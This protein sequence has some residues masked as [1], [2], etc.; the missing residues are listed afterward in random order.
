MAKKYKTTFKGSFWD[1]GAAYHV[2]Y[3]EGPNRKPSVYTDLGIEETNIFAYERIRTSAAFK[4]TY[5]EYEGG[6]PP[7]NPLDIGNIDDSFKYNWFNGTKM[8][9]ASIAYTRLASVLTYWEAK[10]VGVYADGTE[11][12][13]DQ[14]QEDTLRKLLL[15][16]SNKL[17]MA[18]GEGGST[19]CLLYVLETPNDENIIDNSRVP[20]SRGLTIAGPPRRATGGMYHARNTFDDALESGQIGRYVTGGAEDDP[21]AEVVGNVRLAYN[22]NTQMWESANQLMARLVTTLEP[23]GLPKIDLSSLL[24]NATPED[25]YVK[26]A[27]TYV[28]GKATALAIP[29]SMEEGNPDLYGPNFIACEGNKMETMR[30]VNRTNVKMEVGTLIMCHWIDGE[31][32]ATKIPQDT[33][34][35]DITGIPAKVGR[36]QFSKFFV[37]ADGL[38]KDER[39]TSSEDFN[40]NL[41]PVQIE[42]ERRTAFFNAAAGQ[43][44]NVSTEEQ[45]MTE[46]FKMNLNPE[47]P[48][49]LSIP[50]EN[51]E[52]D[53]IVYNTKILQHS[54]FDQAGPELGG[55]A[56]L[57][58]L[59][60]QNIYQRI[61]NPIN[62]EEPVKA[63]F[64]GQLAMF[65]GPVFPQ[66]YKASFNYRNKSRNTEIVAAGTDADGFFTTGSSVSSTFDAAPTTYGDISMFSKSSDVNMVQLPAEIGVNG[67]WDEFSSPLDSW[68]HIEATYLF[69]SD[70]SA[71]TNDAGV[72]DNGAYLVGADSLPVYGMEPVNGSQVQWTA[73]TAELA[74]SRDIYSPLTK[75]YDERQPEPGADPEIFVSNRYDRFFQEDAQVV[76]SN[77]GEGPGG[78]VFGKAF[79][80][81]KNGDKDGYYKPAFPGAGF[82]EAQ[83]TLTYGNPDG[84][85]V[86]E[87]SYQIPYDCMLYKT[88]T[89]TPIAIS[90]VP[91]TTDA[92]REVYGAGLAAV[93]TGRT[94][95]VKNGGGNM[96]IELDMFYGVNGPLIGFGTSITN[97]SILPIGGIGVPIFNSNQTMQQRRLPAWGS[98]DNDDI[99]SFGT[100]ALHMRM[101]DYWPEQYTVFLAPYYSILYFMPGKV[102]SRVDNVEG[103]CTVAFPGTPNAT[104][105]YVD[106]R[107][108]IDEDSEQFQKDLEDGKYIYFDYDDQSQMITEADTDFLLPTYGDNTIVAPGDEFD[109]FTELRPSNKWRVAS[110]KRGWPIQAGGLRWT[111]NYLGLSDDWEVVDGGANYSTGTEYQGP[112]GSRIRVLETGEGGSLVSFEFVEDAESNNIYRGYD[113][114][115]DDFDEDGYEGSVD[116]GA[117]VLWKKGLCYRYYQYFT[118]PKERIP[119]T[120]VST[121]S[122]DGKTRVAGAAIRDY[123]IPDN[124]AESY[125]PGEYEAFFFF[126]NDISYTFNFQKYTNNGYLVSNVQYI[127]MTIL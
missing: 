27:E 10:N 120:R 8:E 1:D 50:G 61:L 48:P 127:S 85:P 68:E 74:C 88:P 47:V 125:Y 110:V 9:E 7:S 98:Q 119:K 87:A 42:F 82:F 38:F 28:G 4:A 106:I 100:T 115:P 2:M 101:M 29:L 116:G 79:D 77:Q 80:R 65:W 99:D 97:I 6:S 34:S 72:H 13:E 114:R 20:V 105:S 102:G 46:F 39:F 41:T 24:D 66:G 117:R 59:A 107:D 21:A 73:C 35:G 81:I 84:E 40:G 118:G 63:D 69:S 16:G 3:F 33:E 25:F 124:R 78:D 126:H 36:W 17:L 14:D 91:F 32:V 70:L 19:R 52:V 113:V 58:S 96:T 86:P 57:T 26:D 95:I 94:K 123:T 49:G 103:I 121:G 89:S 111:E 104:P 109:G 51:P 56:G 45:N 75:T 43:N 15:A 18:G 37:P 44:S 64:Y 12:V 22:Q 23:A 5:Q 71:A 67:P 31:W 122:G 76:L 30:V 11:W 53:S 60:R 90:P 108:D 92:G 93:A 54:A 83:C 55:G 112:K 62:P